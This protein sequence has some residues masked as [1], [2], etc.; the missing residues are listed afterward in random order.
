[1]FKC[2]IWMAGGSNG[3]DLDVVEVFNSFTQTWRRGPTLTRRRYFLTMEALDNSLVVFGGYGNGVES[4]LEKLDKEE[5][6]EE[7]LQNKHW[8]HA[9]VS[10]PCN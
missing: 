10:I 7:P 1:M 9:S 8:R 2:E 4:S 3:E 5:W 6:R